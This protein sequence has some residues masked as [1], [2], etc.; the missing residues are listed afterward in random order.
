M[1]ELTPKDEA[2]VD[3]FAGFF[4]DVLRAAGITMMPGKSH[5]RIREV[6]KKFA[7]SIEWRAEHKAVEVIRILQAALVSSFET[8]E[9]DYNALAVRVKE[10]EEK[11]NADPS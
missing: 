8:I 2:F 4:H 10:L 3:M 9:S 6:A 5:E 11:V 7:T 1:A